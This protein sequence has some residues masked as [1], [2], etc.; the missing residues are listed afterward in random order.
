[1]MKLRQFKV[2]FLIVLSVFSLQCANSKDNNEL[3]SKRILPL[4]AGTFWQIGADRLQRWTDSQLAA[5]VRVIKEMG[6]ELLIIHY[7]AYWDQVS[8]SYHTVVPDMPF[9]TYDLLTNRNPLDAI[10]R[11]AETEGVQIVIGDFLVPPNIRY[12]RPEEAFGHWLSD[13][14][15]DFRH[16]L[17]A[18]Y[19]D[20]PSFYGYYIANEP[21]PNK[22]SSP[23]FERLWRQSTKEV[24][25]L[26]KSVKPELRIIHSIGLYPEWINAMP[27]GPS[28]AFLDRFWKPWIQDID[29]VGVWMLID[30]VGTSLSSH[31]HTA[32]AQKWAQKITHEYKKEYWVDVENAKMTNEFVP[33]RIAQ[34][35]RS[36]EIAAQTADKIVL[37]EHL[38]YMSPNSEKEAAV[39]LYTDYLD[40]RAKIMDRKH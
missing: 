34:L 33:F 1:M 11:A 17:I 28:D 21:N 32:K 4:A 39:K 19:Y 26:V 22:I 15:M 35:K 40:Y 13:E 6:I 7:T 3:P 12:E 38:S 23:A 16:A 29:E 31:A 18:R 30:G 8:N 2:I 36:L 14:A 37:F 10:F 5:E 27:H 20:S 9:R 24:A 25:A